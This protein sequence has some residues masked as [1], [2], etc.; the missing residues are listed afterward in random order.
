MLRARVEEAVAAI[1]RMLEGGQLPSAPNDARCP[2][3]S[4]IEACLPGVIGG[5]TAGERYR[6]LLFGVDE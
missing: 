3:C 1:R 6:A 4:L 2:R 5:D